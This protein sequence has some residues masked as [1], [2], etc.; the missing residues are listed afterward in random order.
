MASK[1][2][3]VGDIGPDMGKFLLAWFIVKGTIKGHFKAVEDGLTSL[4]SGVKELKIAVESMELAHTRRLDN[5]ELE[6]RNLKENRNDNA[7][8]V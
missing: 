1:A 6:V 7:R 2:F 5:L 4:T 8:G 3:T